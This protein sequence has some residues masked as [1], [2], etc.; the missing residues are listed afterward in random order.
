MN[1]FVKERDRAII[2]AVE[3]DDWSMVKKYCRKYGVEIPEDENVFKAGIYK[4]ANACTSIP[5]ETKLKAVEKCYAI[6]FVPIVW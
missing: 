6:W 5:E 1:D 4:A 3:K 2:A